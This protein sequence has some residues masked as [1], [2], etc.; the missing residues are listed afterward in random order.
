MAEIIAESGLSAGAIYGHY[1]SKD[2]LIQSAITEVL[3]ARFTTA[4]P[5]DGDLLP[6]PGEIILRF[7]GGIE[8]DM[9]ALGLLVQV[10]G[11]AVLDPS[12]R[13]AADRIGVR[14]KEIFESYL[15][16]WYVQDLGLQQEAAARQAKKFAGLYLGIM[17]GYIVQSSIFASFDGPAYLEAA[18]AIRPEA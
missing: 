16:R 5:A 4:E 12:S 15:R 14:L 9:G 7:L 10:W 6:P 11:Q 8:H 1:K 17:Q 13:K 3:D 18:S 2:E